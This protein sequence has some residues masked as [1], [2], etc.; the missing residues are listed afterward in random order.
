MSISQHFCQCGIQEYLGFLGLLISEER[1]TMLF[2]NKQASV[3]NF[4]RVGKPRNDGNVN[5]SQNV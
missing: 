2:R 1:F 3:N 5:S 4:M